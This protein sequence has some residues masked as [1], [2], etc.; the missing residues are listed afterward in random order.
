MLFR[1]L[2]HF[3]RIDS[4]CVAACVAQCEKFCDGF[5]RTGVEYLSAARG[6]TVSLLAI[7]FSL[8]PLLIAAAT[9][10]ARRWGPA[11]GGW[12]VGLPL[13][14]GP[15]SVFLALEQGRPFAD[16]AARGAVF[17]VVTI[18]VFCLAY[19]R[20]AERFS[21]LPST[22]AALLCY[23]ASVLLLACFS[24]SLLVSAIAVSVMLWL[25][26]FAIGSSFER[27]FLLAAPRWDLPL[28]MTAATAM[29][30]GITAAAAHLGPELSGLLSPFPVFTYVMAVFSHVQNGP[31]AVRQLMRGVIMGCYSAAAFFIV[32]SLLVRNAPL[33]W[34]YLAAS[35]AA[36]AVNSLTLKAI[37]TG[38]N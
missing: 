28:R 30:M 5:W 7:K 24:H 11:V 19:S 37:V 14:S 8:T 9:L 2:A 35:A 4:F 21:W 27:L 15:V 26:L 25:C 22:V 31:Q 33:V 29:V 1:L 20:C 38:R 18:A 10:T 6:R 13:T 36:I 23:L 16:A 32:V 12:L 34:V 3:L 17:G